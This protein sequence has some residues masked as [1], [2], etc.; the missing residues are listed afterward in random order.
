MN[1]NDGLGTEHAPSSWS[2]ICL[3]GNTPRF[4]SS[5]PATPDTAT[6]PSPLAINFSSRRRETVA[7]PGSL[8]TMLHRSPVKVQCPSC[9]LE[10]DSSGSESH[11]RGEGQRHT[12]RLANSSLE[13]L[14]HFRCA[15]TLELRPVGL[16][17]LV[18]T[19]GGTIERRADGL[20]TTCGP[21][22]RHTNLTGRRK[23]H[24]PQ[25]QRVIES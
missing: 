14:N 22:D 1:D 2:R 17:A 15:N 23:R 9:R 18:R 4:T 13:T 11:Q 19:D 21:F 7:W 3:P 16:L 6:A 25:P 12:F 8:S 24:Y 20:D 5:N 10:S